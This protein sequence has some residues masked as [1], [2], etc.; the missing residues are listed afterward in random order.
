MYM[1]HDYR[2]IS[3]RYADKMAI[4][5]AFPWPLGATGLFA[6]PH[7]PVST[8]RQERQHGIHSD[9]MTRSW[10]CLPILFTLF[11]YVWLRMYE[12]D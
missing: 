6:R 5:L 4:T 9:T 1:F 2:M 8:G 11:T 10:F 3:P 7:R 12:Y